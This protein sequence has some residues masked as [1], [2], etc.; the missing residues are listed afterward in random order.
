MANDLTEILSIE[1]IEATRLYRGDVST[2]LQRAFGGQVMAESLLS[3]YRSVDPA[4]EAHSLHAY[5]LRPGRTDT[6]VLYDVESTRE[7]KSFSSRRVIA[8]QGG[9][10]IFQIAVSFHVREVGLE[11]QDPAPVDVPAPDV[12]PTLA[13]VLAS[14]TG[15]DAETWEREWG[16]LDVRFV[17]DSRAGGGVMPT[18]SHGAHMRVWVRVRECLPED[19]RWHQAGLAYL[20]DLTLLSVATVPHPTMIGDPRLQ[21]A[22]IDHSMW[23]HRPCR[24][25]DWM[26]Y[27]QVSPSASRALGFSVG[28]I[29]QDG[30]LVASCAQEG[31][32]RLV[33]LA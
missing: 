3:A 20:S 31:L 11:H 10:N 27:D 23:F 7:G 33:D 28:R 4:R 25:D 26:L 29:F 15:G 30:Q 17:G 22:S 14:R 8:R 13:E 16:M 24:A 5:F 9:T 2:H 32:I 12:C 18:Q 19:L 6:P 1:E 21:A